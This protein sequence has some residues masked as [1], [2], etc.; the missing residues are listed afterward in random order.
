MD[1]EIIN[2][3]KKYKKGELTEEE[4][5]KKLKLIP[6]IKAGNLKIDSH[7]RFRRRFPE[8]IYGKGKSIKQLQELLI[9]YVEIDEEFIIT[10][11]EK[12]K[13]DK[14]KKFF[15]Q[16]YKK[17]NIKYYQEGRV[18]GINIK[19]KTRKGLITIITAGAV[20]IP[21][22]EEC[23]AICDL[24]G[25]K[26][27]KI[28]DAG[29]AGIHRLY[30]YYDILHKSNVIVVM[31]GMEGALPAAVASLVDIPVIGVPVSAGYG[32]SFGGITALLTML[33]TC[34]PGLA[35]VGIDNGFGAGYFASLINH[36]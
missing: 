20:D 1:K 25:N 18:L 3:L 30:E 31:A 32:T 36:S 5:I 8:V 29:I 21:V 15:K 13:A 27:E 34:V 24:F 9:K 16:K 6:F 12:E 28:Y 14:L 17:N 4:V 22:A 35:V 23:Y 19:P 11:L 26:T 2:T 7:R 33:S 10:K